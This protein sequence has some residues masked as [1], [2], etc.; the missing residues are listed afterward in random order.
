MNV[1]VE[2]VH[3]PG[4]DGCRRK[5]DQGRLNERSSIICSVCMCMCRCQHPVSMDWSRKCVAKAFIPQAACLIF[6]SMTYCIKLQSSHLTKAWSALT[7]VR[8]SW[9]SSARLFFSF[10]CCLM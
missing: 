4:E 3:K 9:F 8:S 10:S 2:K 7:L 5:I 6:R 1:W